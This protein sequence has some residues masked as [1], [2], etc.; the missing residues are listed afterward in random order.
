MTLEVTSASAVFLLQHTRDP[1]LS[2]PHQKTWAWKHSLQ[3]GK[4]GKYSIF[5]IMII[6]LLNNNF[7][8]FIF[9]PYI[10]FQWKK[11]LFSLARP[12]Y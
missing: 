7:Y 1:N 9:N 6:L 10:Y 12:K 11:F 3:G 5:K 4:L 2:P 8:K